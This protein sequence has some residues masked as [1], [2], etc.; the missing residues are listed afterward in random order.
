MLFKKHFAWFFL[1]LVLVSIG[2][3]NFTSID[4]P[5]NDLILTIIPAIGLI[6]AL[7]AFTLFLF[8]FKPGRRVVVLAG[9]LMLILGAFLMSFNSNTL[10]Y[11]DALMR[12]MS[13]PAGG[14]YL[15][16]L[17]SLFV[18]FASLA[19]IIAALLL[20]GD[21]RV[22]LL[23]MTIQIIG[24]AGAVLLPL[25]ATLD[26]VI[27]VSASFALVSGLL[28]LVKKSERDFLLLN[29]NMRPVA[30]A[31]ASTVNNEGSGVLTDA[32]NGEEAVPDK[33]GPGASA[34]WSQ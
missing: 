10:T 25:S 23:T 32:T 31:P 15:P 1:I 17:R 16:G 9:F 19:E 7:I 3:Y 26:S 13:N 33:S 11:S 8:V 34:P 14:V 30:A 29:T 27:Y 6:S 20:L 5:Y 12:L 22:A 28:V 21:Q 18:L 24:L 4:L 2:I